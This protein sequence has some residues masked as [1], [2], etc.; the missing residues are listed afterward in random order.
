MSDPVVVVPLGLTPSSQI[1]GL[2]VPPSL[3]NCG[4]GSVILNGQALS[5][6]SENASSIGRG[7]I[8]TASRNGGPEYMLEAEWESSCLFL[9]ESASDD[10][11]AS[12]SPG[13]RGQFLSLT[14][15]R[16]DGRP[17]QGENG[18]SASYIQYPSPRILR[19]EPRVLAAPDPG[20]VLHWLPSSSAKKSTLDSAESASSSSSSSSSS[21][22]EDLQHL[23]R[24]E[25]EMQRLKG[26]IKIQKR[27]VWSH[28]KAELNNLKRDVGRCDGI[29][30]VMTAAID[31][32]QRALKMF[33]AA[34]RRAG[35]QS[36]PGETRRGRWQWLWNLPWNRKLSDRLGRRPSSQ[37]DRSQVELSSTTT[38]TETGRSPPIIIPPPAPANMEAP[39]PTHPVF[40]AWTPTD[41]RGHEV[42]V[43]AFVTL[44]IM[45]CTLVPIFFLLLI[46]RRCSHPCRVDRRW[47][48]ESRHRETLVRRAYRRQAL[49]RWWKNLWRDSRITDYEEKRALIVEQERI[50]ECAMQ[51]ELRQLRTAAEAVSSLVRSDD[52]DRDRAPISPAR[53]LHDPPPPPPPGVAIPSALARQAPRH[54]RDSLP[55]YRSEASYV[56]PPPT[57][58]DS[59]QDDHHLGNM[60]VDG[61][62]YRSS[63]PSGRYTPPSPRWSPGSSVVGTSVRG[64]VSSDDER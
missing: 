38:S 55:D 13:T 58:D 29:M 2:D 4:N 7:N 59:N 57:Y 60:V 53:Q 9:P 45:A 3:D 40:R 26:H 30:C 50:L 47:Q 11:Q 31:R 18:F 24:L 44:Q 21:F 35:T 62:Q 42:F 52:G 54:R 19:L 48:R 56:D 14:I 8:W 16:L 17:I 1:F 49:R 36:R 63:L 37:P 32:S 15:K 46:F 61:F 51:E 34:R 5:R 64:D 10:H 33:D 27:L 23:K 39:S 28:V 41:P 43:A 12:S 25:A 22:E 20:S 6:G